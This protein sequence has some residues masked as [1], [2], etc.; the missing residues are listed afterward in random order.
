MNNSNEL[1][2]IRVCIQKLSIYIT[3]CDA[4]TA[5]TIRK[6]MKIL[7]KYITAKHDRGFNP[8]NQTLLNALDCYIIK[9]Q[10][11][12]PADIIF[13]VNDA[14]EIIRDDHQHIMGQHMRIQNMRDIN[15]SISQHMMGQHMMGQH[16]MGQHMMGQ[17]MMEQHMMGQHM[18]GQHMM[19]QHMMGQH[20][21]G[22]HMIGQ[23]IMGQHMMGQ[24][25][26]GQHMIGQHMMGQHIMGQQLDD[27]EKYAKL[28][29]KINSIQF[30]ELDPDDMDIS[31]N[32]Q[33]YAMMANS[34]SEIETKYTN[35]RRE[36]NIIR[37]RLTELEL[38]P[39]ENA[40]H[41]YNL[42]ARLAIITD[43]TSKFEKRNGGGASKF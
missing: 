32:D 13:L 4:K 33:Q 25:I 27:C 30:N 38:E 36:S 28:L 16:M 5:S 12:V 42:V 6:I 22:Q 35:L 40:K 31:H 43:Q 29:K 39:N 1:T 10:N 24:H 15:D 17:H 2:T 21:I 9:I 19:E 37:N 3:R 7:G 18:M 23:H 26:M 8:I 11:D 34:I 14:A 41:I 20:M